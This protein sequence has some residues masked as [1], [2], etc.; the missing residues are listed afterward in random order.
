MHSIICI[1]SLYGK[2]KHHCN[3]RYT[4]VKNILIYSN[5]VLIQTNLFSTNS[6]GES[7]WH[8]D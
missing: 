2:K 1:A 3:I 6:F 5:H 4:D 7:A 8:G